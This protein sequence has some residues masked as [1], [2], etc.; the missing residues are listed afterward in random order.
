MT[1]IHFLQHVPF[2]TPAYIETLADKTCKISTTRLFSGDEFPALTEFD[3]LVVL[4]GP[5]N[6]Y[7]DDRYPWLPKEKEFI[8]SA[9]RA[10]KKVLGICLG[11]QLIA[12]ALGAKVE[13]N[14]HKEIGWFQ[15]YRTPES[16]TI[17]VLEGIPDS[18]FAFHWHGDTFQIPKGAIRITASGACGNQGFVYNEKVIALQFHIEVTEQSISSL[19]ANCGEEI[20]E[21]KY[22]QTEKEI[23]AQA[24][25]LIL[26]TNKYISTLFRNIKNAGT[27]N[28]GG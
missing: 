14:E 21:S 1:R 10:D 23:Q 11:A 27:P 2:E 7:E 12:N 3:F 13:K 24:K 18:F 4:G 15:V 9:I 26:Q 6:I 16:N 25:A 8:A 22:I 5:M 20:V 17:K 19:L 28:I